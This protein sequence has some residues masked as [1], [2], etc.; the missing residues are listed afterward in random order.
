MTLVDC[1]LSFIFLKTGSGLTFVDSSE[2]GDA[3]HF[4]CIAWS[5]VRMPLV[6]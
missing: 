4:Y 3:C 1:C 2:I 6:L 5:E